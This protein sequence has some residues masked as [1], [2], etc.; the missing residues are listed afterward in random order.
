VLQCIVRLTLGVTLGFIWVA[1]SGLALSDAQ[2][3]SITV[4]HPIWVSR[5]N[6]T[7]E[8]YELI[9][10]I[11]PDDSNHMLACTTVFSARTNARSNIIYASVDNGR[12]W[13]PTFEDSATIFTG[14]PDCAFARHG[15]AYYAALPIYGGS[16]LTAG[17]HIFESS[18]YGKTWHRIAE[19][20]FLDREY[21]TIDRT[22]S[23][24]RGNVYMYADGID[25]RN[26]KHS[27]GF[28]VERIVNGR[29]VPSAVSPD[30]SR[31]DSMNASQGAIALDG[32]LVIPFEAPV[33]KPVG[34]HW[35]ARVM[36]STDGGKAL[37]R[38]TLLTT[39]C[40]GADLGSP[41]GVDRSNG[42]FRKRLYTAY[43]VDDNGQCVLAVFYSDDSG[44]MWSHPTLLHEKSQRADAQLPSE[45]QPALAVNNKGVVGVSWYDTRDDPSGRAYKLRFAASY[46]GGESFEPSAEV[47]SHPENIAASRPT[48]FGAY[49]DTG[50]ASASRSSAVNDPLVSMAGPDW[51][52]QNRP[53]DTRS[54]LTDS[55]D[56]FHPFW[57]DNESG[58]PQLYTAP[59]QVSGRAW[60]HGDPSLDVYADV[61]R[62]VTLRYTSTEFDPASKMLTLGVAVVNRTKAPI[63]G[64]LKMRILWL[65][66]RSG[67]P[68]ALNAQNGRQGSGAIWEFGAA[69]NDE[70]LLPWAESRV[71]ALKFSMRHLNLSRTTFPMISFGA[72]VY[73]RK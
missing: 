29:L 4:G 16:H 48:F 15:V 69:A 21:I 30:S 62:R 67:M 66:S 60:R 52:T 57:Y 9:A 32:T 1:T 12:T 54:M 31:Y 64:P 56:A 39:L 17:L 55:G 68:I 35:E 73:G 19:R 34:S 26:G 8:H 44:K 71:I 6:A 42:P 63:H 5:A 49:V 41:V 24:W 14:D 2:E 23:P 70:V 7:R 46:D 36:R 61:T 59:I 47:S 58:I 11:D 72:R 25:T 53:G 40:K 27:D 51:M 37:L 13:T 50:G 22:S 18:D 28:V 20:S 43:E 10:D 38:S 3:H 45:H 65:D 33:G